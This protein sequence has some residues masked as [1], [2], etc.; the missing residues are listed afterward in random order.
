[1][2]KTFLLV[3]AFSA[4]VLFSQDFDR[5]K[6]LFMTYNDA[7][8]HYFDTGKH[9]RYFVMEAHFIEKNYDF[10]EQELRIFTN[11]TTRTWTLQIECNPNIPNLARGTVIK[12]YYH[13]YPASGGNNP[14]F[15][16]F[17]E[18]VNK[19][20]I[21]GHVY[22]PFE[23][24]NIRSGPTTSSSKITTI[25]KYDAVWILEEGPE[26]TIDG[27][28]SLWVKVRLKSG[29]TGWAFGGYLEYWNRPPVEDR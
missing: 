4:A 3:F 1:M 22:E 21:I 5:S 12:V 27:I 2:K 18:P 15:I 8:G 13:L 16:D 7:L 20:F 24:L 10:R 19:R 28:N 9:D 25:R 14:Q 29:Q 23:N 11:D 26:E 6:Y 17:I